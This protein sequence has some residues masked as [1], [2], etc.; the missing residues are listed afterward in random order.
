VRIKIHIKQYKT[1]IT[2]RHPIAKTTGRRTP[3][4][5]SAAYAPLAFRSRDHRHPVVVHES[6]SLSAAFRKADRKLLGSPRKILSWLALQIIRPVSMS[7]TSSP[8]S[9]VRS[10]L[11]DSKI[12]CEE[13]KMENG[14]GRQSLGLHTIKLTCRYASVTAQTVHATHTHKP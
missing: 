2:G 7:T 12:Y 4:R 14:I 8:G 5:D 3:R 13:K 6:S 1:M 10:K 9:P 11:P